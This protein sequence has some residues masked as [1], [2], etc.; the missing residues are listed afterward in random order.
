MSETETID[1]QFIEYIVKTLV[2]NPDKVR[3]ERTIDER[4][5]LLQL[6]VDPEDLGRV[7]GRMGTTAKSIR[8][9]LRALGMKNDARYNLKIVDDGQGRPP[10]RDDR[11]YDDNRSS[12]QPDSGD[13]SN[14]GVTTDAPAEPTEQPA[15]QPVDQPVEEPVAEPAEEPAPQEAP[16]EEQSG[17]DRHREDLKDLTDLD[18]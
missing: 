9:L 12:D 1:Q 10:R 5:V 7:I 11:G 3:V 8:T 15:E 2:G 18:I 13:S 17:V 6:H 4:G 16:V 14:D